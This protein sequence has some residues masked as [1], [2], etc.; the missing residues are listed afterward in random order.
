MDHPQIKYLLDFH[1]NNTENTKAPHYG[2]FAEVGHQRKD[3]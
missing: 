3:Q 2:P 1:A